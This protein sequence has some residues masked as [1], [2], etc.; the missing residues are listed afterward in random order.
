MVSIPY[1]LATNF[2]IVEP[3]DGQQFEFQFLIGWLQTKKLVLL[4]KI[5]L[6]FQFLIGWLQTA[7]KN[8]GALRKKLF[9]FLI[10]WLQ[11]IEVDYEVYTFT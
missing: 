8:P 3:E 5:T 10:G 2:K 6:E 9:Q 11:T 7:I 4:R 1:R